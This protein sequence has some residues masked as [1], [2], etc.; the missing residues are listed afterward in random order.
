MSVI[1]FICGIFMMIGFIL[2]IGF[3]PVIC[4]ISRDTARYVWQ[5]DTVFTFIAYIAVMYILTVIT[6]PI[7]LISALRD[8]IHYF[9]TG[10]TKFL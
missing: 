3:F 7:L 8:A 9:K 5:H 10:T 1:E 2:S 6:W 4:Y